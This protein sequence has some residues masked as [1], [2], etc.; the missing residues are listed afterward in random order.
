MVYILATA[1]LVADVRLIFFYLMYKI[2][3]D[4]GVVN[5]ML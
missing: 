3:N 1:G 5:D 2:S 4:I